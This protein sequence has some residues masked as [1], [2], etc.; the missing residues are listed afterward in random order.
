[1]TE[2]ND[3]V[4]SP[5]AATAQHAVTGHEKGYHSPAEIID[6][7]PDTATPWQQDSAIRANYNF[8]KIDWNRRQ[9]PMRT[10]TTRADGI[11]T[12][13]LRKAMYYSPSM[14][15]PD[16][17]Y[18]PECVAYRHGVA[19]DPVPYSIAG[20]DLITSILLVCF[21]IA[22][23]AIAKSGNFLQRQ[24]KNFFH[25]QREGTSAITETGEELRFQFF[26]MLQTCLLSAIILFFYSREVSGEA[27]SFAHYQ[28]L[29]AYTGT[30][31]VY[32]ILKNLLYSVVNWVFFDKKKN[33]Q[34]AKSSLFLSSAEGMLL[35]PD[36]M[37]LAYFSLPV[38][39]AAIYALAVIVIVKLLSFYKANIIFFRRKGLFLQSFLY[40]CALELMPLGALWGVMATMDRYLKQNF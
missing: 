39:H 26:L 24:L 5:V 31:A 2:R 23:T 17:T 40:F 1:M 28:I 29:S 18:R 9:N 13:S 6:R 27:F 22:T 32:F 12:F 35:F 14:V 7:L 33:E 36:V 20:D 21:I 15:Q 8:Q 10:P 4:N 25:S 3:S 34:W 37:L 19:G 11:G 16:S 38:K 30:L